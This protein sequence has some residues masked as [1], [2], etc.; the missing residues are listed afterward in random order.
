MCCDTAQ[1]LVLLLV[2]VF[3]STLVFLHVLMCRDHT[4]SF[5]ADTGV[6]VLSVPSA[7]VFLN[8]RW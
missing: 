3:V 2:S 7:L 8:C 5:S 1:A 6:N 4:P